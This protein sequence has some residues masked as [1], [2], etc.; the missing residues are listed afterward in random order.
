MVFPFIKEAMIKVIFKIC[1][2][3]IQ[4]NNKLFISVAPLSC[5]RPNMTCNVFVDFTQPDLNKYY[6]NGCFTI[7]S[8]AI[9][10]I[11]STKYI[12]FSVIIIQV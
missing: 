5:C 12:Y 10:S 3:Y 1:F 2:R 7:I 9:N 11:E 8:D 6:Q 4:N